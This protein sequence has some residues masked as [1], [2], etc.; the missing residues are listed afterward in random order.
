MSQNVAIMTQQMLMAFKNQHVDSAE[1]CADRILSIKPKDLLALQIKGLTLAL[2]GK[3]SESASFLAKASLQDPKNPELL[4]NL[5][6][7]Q[8]DAGLYAEALKTYKLLNRISP[9]NPQV[10]NDM[11]TAFAKCGIDEEAAVCFDKA[12]E[13][14]PEHFLPWS[15]RG[16]IYSRF[17]CIPEAIHC[18]ENALKLNPGFPETWTNYGNVF[19]GLGEYENALKAHKK[20]LE[21]NP[22]YAEAWS[23]QGNTQLE[24]KDEATL[25][26]YQRAYSLKP[27][28]PFLMGQLLDV[29]ASQCNWKS[30]SQLKGEMLDRVRLGKPVAKPFV[31]LQIGEADL[32][33][34]GKC[35]Q[36]YIQNE[37]GSAP[38]TEPFKEKNVDQ[39]KIRIGYFSSDF[40]AHPVGILMENLLRHHDRSKFEIFG[41]FLNKA[42][43]DEHEGRLLQLFDN[44]NNLHLLNDLDAFNLIRNAHLDIA[45]DLNGHTSGART[46]LFSRR[47][48]PIQVNYLGY[49]GTS[50]AHFIDHLIAD[51]VAIPIEHEGFYS[52][53]IAR[54]PHS[55]FP[56]DTSID[57]DELG[58][59]PSRSSQGLPDVGFIFACF[60]NAYKI[61]PEIFDIWMQLLLKTPNSVLW[62]SSPSPSALESLKLEA[63]NRGV[64]PSRLIFASRTDGRPEHL[65]RL[66]LAD[67][68]LDTP[69]YN[70]HATAADALW[71][72]VP[73]LTVL[74]N[75]FAGRVAS[76][77]LSALGLN[78]LI[79][80]STEEYLNAALE[81]A[82]HPE[83]LKAIR[84]FLVSNRE[85]SPL[86]N[87]RQY[88]QDLEALYQD[89]LSPQH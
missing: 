65:S 80:Q 14:N 21:L 26:S 88:V 77:Q 69:I 35:A 42:T 58:Q 28:H 36:I 82:H 56:V 67:L 23:N 87:T 57:I 2:Q 44:V 46:K 47:L 43:G 64:D 3:F 61:T 9:N 85:N 59:V 66:R 39:N 60:N 83:K 34:Q 63:G 71:A 84:S 79:C 53:N 40:K 48:A 74:G 49:A 45:I 13:L 37:I 72:G 76:S 50:G 1:R 81:L 11:G 25:S 16:N 33:V 73:V 18:Y 17:G 22:E 55:F 38:H 27:E 10:L 78:E 52:E 51:R 15:N 32:A 4:S 62:L 68:F 7:A 54:L 12:I 5:G 31:L 19:Y 89:F 20:S 70:A 6:K 8:H 24:L 41:Y 30:V 86:F 75:T 29:F